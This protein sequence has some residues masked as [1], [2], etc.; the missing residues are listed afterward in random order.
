MVA[1]AAKKL[2]ASMRTISVGDAWLDKPSDIS[3]AAGTVSSKKIG[4]L[5][6]V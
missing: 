3:P 5:W 4:A 6:E 2:P 1:E